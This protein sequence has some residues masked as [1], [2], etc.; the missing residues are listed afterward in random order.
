MIIGSGTSVVPSSGNG[1]QNGCTQ[2]QCE[3]TLT[4]CALSTFGGALGGLIGAA[5]I[6][7][8]AGVAAPLGAAIGI[9]AAIG[10]IASATAISINNCCNGSTSATASNEPTAS[11][12]ANN[13]SGAAITIHNDTPTTA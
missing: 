4:L 8:F 9:G 1:A 7:A 3:N 11:D 2:K 6:T 13:G 12:A 10:L 5:T